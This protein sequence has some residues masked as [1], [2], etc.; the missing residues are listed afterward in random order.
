[1]INPNSKMKALWNVIM[2]ILVLFQAIIVPPR[3]AFEEQT[4]WSWQVADYIMDG[5][6]MID[7]VVNFITVLENDVGELITD[8]K[9]IAIAY[10]KGWFWIDFISCAPIDL[11]FNLAQQE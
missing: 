9:K 7:I 11:M 4:P 10:L 8:R 1:M 5:L 3:I 2:L 6:F